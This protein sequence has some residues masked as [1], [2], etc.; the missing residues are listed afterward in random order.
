MDKFMVTT[1]IY[2]INDIPHIG[3]TYA[4]MAADTLARYHRLLGR[5]VLFSTGTDEHGQKVELAAQERGEDPQ[6]YVDE[7]SAAWQRLWEDLD[8][9]NTD[10]IRTTQPRHIQVVRHFFEKMIASGDIYKGEYSGWYCTPCETFWLE[11]QLVDGCC[12]NPECRRPVHVLKEESY[13]FRLS[14]YQETLLEYYETHPDFI[15]PEWRRNE[16]ISFVK[17]G[18]QDTCVSRT[19]FSWGIELP[20]EPAHVAYVWFDALINYV[21]VAGYLSDEA[22][23]NRFWPADVHLIGKDILR[24]HA[25]LWPAMLMSV[26]L[27]LPGKIFAHGFWTSEG[28]KISKSKGNKVDPVE[29]ITEL[30]QEFGLSHK[31]ALEA[32]RYFLLR[33]VPFGNDGDFSRTALKARIN[34]DLANDI[35]NLLYRTLSM[36]EKY[37][38]GRVPASLPDAEADADIQAVCR[39]ALAAFGRYT[40]K[41]AYSLA[42]AELWRFIGRMNKYIDE[43][44]PWALKREGKEQRLARVMYNVLEA[45]RQIAV[46]LAPYMPA[47]SGCIQEQLGLASGI[48]IE[49]WQSLGGWDILKPGLITTKA[50]PLFPRLEEVGRKRKSGKQKKEEKKTAAVPAGKKGAA[51]VKETISY[52]DFAKVDLQVARVVAAE[53]VVG[54]DKLLKLEI[55]LGEESTRTIVAGVAEHYTPEEII[56][57]QIVVVANLEPAVIR[58]VASNGMLLAASDKDKVALLTPD[59]LMTPGSKV[60]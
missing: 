22:K 31:L 60:K 26:G 52:E 55:D 33:E 58:G 19:S 48:T 17:S 32:L 46:A 13:F 38:D 4:T 10:F 56:G 23:F 29:V 34:A 30:K 12:P 47:T 54:T 35:G 41:L 21:T 3:H 50:A 1:P 40:E 5:E 28:E 14:R 6:T 49:D 45:L 37:F 20:R 59:L 7:M 39:E 53:K 51:P 15:Q 18:L 42:L 9:S 44:A 43:Q 57:R 8:I 27:P 25:I 36:L 11:S 16:V 2:Y 24:F